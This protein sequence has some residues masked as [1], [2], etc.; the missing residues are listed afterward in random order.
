MS[1]LKQHW[2]G[3]YTDNADD[4]LSW[5]ES[6]PFVSREWITSAASSDSHIVDI[7]AGRSRLIPQ[8]LQAGF[9]QL[10][11]VELSEKAS[12]EVQERLGGEASK[13]NWYVGD[14]K[15]WRTHLPVQVWHDRAVFHFLTEPDDRKAYI[16]AVDENL[17]PNGTVIIATFHLTG[18]QKC[19]GLSVQQYD[20]QALLETFN[21]LSQWNWRL[22]DE[23]VHEHLTPGGNSQ[24]FQYAKL[25][26]L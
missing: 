9:A 18:P 1:T 14:A 15:C 16:A 13:V 22:E 8:L 7:G 6:D 19:S 4:D 26:R 17:A 25:T 12:T 24:I 11:H 5:T 2:E 23:L 3:R 21:S 10:T 20:A